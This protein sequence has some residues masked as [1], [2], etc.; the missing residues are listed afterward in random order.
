MVEEL[1]S[2]LGCCLRGFQYQTHRANAITTAE[3]RSAW[4]ID[5]CDTNGMVTL[6]NIAL[7]M[8]GG[9]D[10]D[11]FVVDHDLVALSDGEGYEAI[12]SDNGPSE[13]SPDSTSPIEKPPGKR[14]RR[15]KE[16]ERKAKVS[17]PAPFTLMDAEK[18]TETETG[19]S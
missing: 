17:F 5:F 19:R 9:D 1:A 14:K 15:E 3:T 6:L 7:P 8:Y 10:L 12:L 16:K 13:N 18:K 4:D 11:D 2:R